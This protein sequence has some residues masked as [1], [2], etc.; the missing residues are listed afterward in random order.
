MRTVLSWGCLAATVL[1]FGCNSPHLAILSDPAATVP[2]GSSKTF[3]ALAQDSDGQILWTLSGPGSLDVTSGPQVTYFAPATYDP[4]G[5]HSAVLK[6]QLTDAHEEVRSIAITITQPSTSIGEFPGLTSNVT[7][8]YDERDIPT[9]SC[10][11]T[12]DCYAVLGY[13]HARDRFFQMDFYRRAGRGKLS[14]LVGEGALSQDKLIRTVFTTRTGAPLP[15]ALTTY[16]QNDPYVGPRLAAYTRG[17]NAWISALRSDAK[18]LPAAYGQL[19]Y[20]ITNSQTDIPDWSDVDTA[21]V[22]RLFQ[23]QL[24]E[25]IEKEVDYGRWAQT[26]A[27]NPVAVGV[28]IQAKSTMNSYTLAG[29]GAP[30][31]PTMTAA[32][33]TLDTLRSSAGALRNAQEFLRP[34][35][36]LRKKMGPFGSNNWVVDKDHSATGQ[37]LVANDPHQPLTYPSNFHLSHLIGSEDG[38]N[39]LGAVFPGVP[40]ALIGRGTHVGWG[41]TVVGYDV[42]DLYVE[43]LVFQGQQPVAV[44]FKGNPVPF[45]PVNQTIGVR[46]VVGIEQRPFQVVVVPH[47]GPVISLDAAGGTA[48]TVRWTGHET[49]TDD[50]RAFFRL[51]NA[52]NV[53][54]ARAALEGNDP[55]PD[56]GSYTGYYTGAQNFVLADDQGNIG[57]VPHACVPQRPW[58]ASSAIYPYPVVPVPGTGNFEWATGPDGGLLCVP[59]DKLPRALGSNKGYLATANADPL[60]TTQ[61]N[62]PYANNPGGVPYLSF[63]WSDKT[64]FRIAR[65]QEVLDAKTANGGKVSLDDIHALQAD[66]VVI[67]ARLFL[68]VFEALHL[69]QSTDANVAAAATMLAAWGM[70]DGGT[71]LDCPTGLVAGALDPV[72]ALNDPDPRRSSDSASCLLFHTFL[73]RVLDTT[74]SDEVAAA[75]I[76]RNLGN[77]VRALLTLL[78]GA[79]PT[80]GNPLCSD[81]DATGQKVKDRDCPT[82]VS[83]ALGWAW[84]RLKS[85]YGDTSNWRWGRVHTLTFE[86][87]VPGYPLIDAPFQ[88]GPFPRPGGAGTVDVGAG[89]ALAT[90]SNDLSFPYTSGG[91]VRW[92]AS[93]DGTLANTTNQLPGVESGGPWSGSPSSMLSQW[94]TNS[95]FNWPFQQKDVTSLRTETYT[96]E[97]P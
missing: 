47:H 73:R 22:A 83:D 80:T 46:Q 57:Y 21:A 94:V 18:L 33:E 5:Q 97:T 82:Q 70:S 2:A 36:S 13:I 20:T 72:T 48:I 39:V 79:V 58:A 49:A 71:A 38:L 35:Q 8:T 12:V 1:V 26:F 43:Q 9:I 32:P 65:I 74:F 77:E 55:N 93:M 69:R 96:P 6:A 95:Y 66:H 17:V 4:A 7:V 59:N 34:L 54:D 64:A 85:I 84:A 89:S 86:F 25:D 91:A 29:T 88:P 78:S 45:H 87:V 3:D 41:D 40:T 56:G 92:A 37:S 52:A 16:A 75:G 44:M 14:E 61:D 50:I 31:A 24:S 51:N 27:A 19:Q 63:D 53:D 60:G 67:G 28:W 76:S 81:V 11:K 68:Q 10:I 15:E 90:S 23:F 62:D 30:N 42:T